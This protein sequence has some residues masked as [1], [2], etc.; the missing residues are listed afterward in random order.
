MKALR[1]LILLK[2]IYHTTK[3]ASNANTVP[4]YSSIRDLVVGMY[5]IVTRRSERKKIKRRRKPNKPTSTNA[6]FVLV[7]LKRDLGSES[8]N[9]GITRRLRSWILTCS[10]VGFNAVTATLYVLVKRP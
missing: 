1:Y 3:V 7:D 9:T 8:T 2:R 10:I 5:D 4:K 6:Q